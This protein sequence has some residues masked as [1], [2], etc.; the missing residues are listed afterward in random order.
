MVKV[1]EPS[2]QTYQRTFTQHIRNP[3]DHAKPANV[4]AKRMAIYTEIVY[5][6]I[7]GTLA[8][9]FPVTKNIL[10]A[11]KWQALVCG[12]LADFKAN[13]P[14]FREVPQQFLQYLN[15]ASLSAL[16]LPP[17]LANLM[18]YEWVELALTTIN[19]TAEL[20]T[21]QDVLLDNLTVNLVLFLLQY[22]YPVHQISVNFQPKK[23]ASTPTYLLVFRNNA[24][25]IEFV[26]LNPMTFQLVALLQSEK[27]SGEQALLKLADENPQIAKDIVLQFGEQTLVALAEKGVIFG[28]KKA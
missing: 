19:V 27:F 16:K 12:F 26:E 6:N 24:Y 8:S 18:H 10:S 5:N 11:K 20:T 3:K 14:L 28:T 13:T 15:T 1:S 4:P 2:F 9:C 22:D 7:E 25:Q 17:F 23:A 21:P